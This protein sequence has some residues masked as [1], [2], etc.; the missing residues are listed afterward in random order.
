MGVMVFA[1]VEV[2]LI[3]VGAGE[4]FTDE[5]LKDRENK[6][7]GRDLVILAVPVTNTSDILVVKSVSLSLDFDTLAFNA[8]GLALSPS[9]PNSIVVEDIGPGETKNALIRIVTSVIPKDPTTLTFQF[10]VKSLEL[11]VD[12]LVQNNLTTEVQKIPLNQPIPQN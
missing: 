10:T 3:K 5:T 11:A 1:M 6:I 2:P 12:P 9:P 4:F 8:A 7:K